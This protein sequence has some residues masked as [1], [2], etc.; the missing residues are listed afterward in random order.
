MSISIF[1][2]ER[3][4][5]RLWERVV[6]RVM[7]RVRLIGQRLAATSEF[8]GR[9]FQIYEVIARAEERWSRWVTQAD[10]H[11]AVC[12]R[13]L[14]QKMHVILRPGETRWTNRKVCFGCQLETSHPDEH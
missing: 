2:R 13:C 9:R 10:L 1:E 11:L 5:V 8:S 12:P 14:Q 6:S 4:P 7:W 3:P